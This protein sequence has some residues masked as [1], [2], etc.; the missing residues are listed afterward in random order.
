V[1]EIKIDAKPFEDQTEAMDAALDQMP[2]AIS[3]ALNDAA[4]ETYNSLIE[5]TWP[6][7]VKVRNSNFIRWALRTKF[8]TKLDLRVEIYDNTSDQRAHLSLH[9]EGGVKTPRGSRLAIPTTNVSRGAGGVSKNQSPQGLSNK[10]VK[11]NLI[12]Q[13]VGRGKNK[14]LRLMYVLAGSAR[15]PMDVP[16]KADFETTM[17]DSASKH[18]K[19][20]M[21]QAMRTRK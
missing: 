19:E 16:F 6:R 5:N 14:K 2:F 21:M 8:S 20:R 10:V 13:S 15:Q 3:R 4:D 9:A 12:F 1:F 17:T 7:S 11:G 18:F